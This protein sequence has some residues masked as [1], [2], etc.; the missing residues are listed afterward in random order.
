MVLGEG[1]AVLWT[2]RL[3]QNKRVDIDG[4]EG[5]VFV[6]TFFMPATPGREGERESEGRREGEGGKEGERE[7]EGE[8]G[9]E[10]GRKEER[11]EKRGEEEGGREEE[12]E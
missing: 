5:T 7:R 2:E 11:E 10:G 8:G 6:L 4:A 9:R 1:D 12:G 3:R